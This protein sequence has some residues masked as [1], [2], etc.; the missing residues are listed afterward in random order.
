MRQSRFTEEQIIPILR[1]GEAGIGITELCRRHGITK[2]NFLPLE[3]EVRRAERR[4]GAAA[5][6]V[7][8]RE[9]PAEAPRGR[10]HTG[11]CSAGQS[12]PAHVPCEQG[13]APSPTD[14]GD[15]ESFAANPGLAKG[16]HPS[17]RCH[18]VA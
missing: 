13:S 7:G 8:R 17:E 2:Q 11:Q 6:A 15:I 3:G 1:E 18:A 14:R 9:P 10:S 4:R 12:E 16:S 5:A